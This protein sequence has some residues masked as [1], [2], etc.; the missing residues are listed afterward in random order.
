[1]AKPRPG[2]KAKTKATQPQLLGCR[3]PYRP[4][5]LVSFPC[6][7]ALET[8]SRTRPV[9]GKSLAIHSPQQA[10]RMLRCRDSL[11][12]SR[13]QLGVPD[14]FPELEFRLLLHRQIGGPGALK[15]RGHVTTGEE[16]G[17]VGIRL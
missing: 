12:N 3:H 6:N 14:P 10:E 5:Q 9:N 8:A 1:M 17:E 7:S 16:I 15:D 11:A 13:G 2:K 4:G